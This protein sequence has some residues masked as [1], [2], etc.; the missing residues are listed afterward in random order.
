MLNM[1]LDV[2][3]LADIFE[4]FA[5]TVVKNYKTN[6]TNSYSLPSYTWS[7]RVK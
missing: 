5:K 4:T 7:A 2:L 1:Q 6:T 3:L